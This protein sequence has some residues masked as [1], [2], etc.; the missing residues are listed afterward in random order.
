[1]RGAHPTPGTLYGLSRF[2]GPTTLGLCPSSHQTED[3]PGFLRVSPFSPCDHLLPS[4]RLCPAAGPLAK[5]P[6]GG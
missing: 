1:M 6:N 4:C 3:T 5:R 2:I